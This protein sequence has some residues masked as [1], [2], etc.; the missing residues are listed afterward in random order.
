[1]SVKLNDKEIS[2]L[3]KKIADKKKKDAE[4]RIAEVA[5]KKLPEAKKIITM[6]QNLP[7]VAIDFI[8]NT[9][10]D[11]KY[12]TAQGLAE[13]MARKEEL[14]EKIDQK[15]YEPDIVLAA[16]GCS[17]LADLCKKLGI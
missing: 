3:A 4:K 14:M 1:M 13:R 5:K 17:S 6:I 15:D 11:K 7:D 9:R 8:D 12:R 10:Y 2:A 16:H